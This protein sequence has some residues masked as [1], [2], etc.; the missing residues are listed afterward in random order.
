MNSK[1]TIAFATALMICGCK[2]QK[3]TISTEAPAPLVLIDEAFRKPINDKALYAATFDAVP[4]DTAYIHHDTLHINTKKVHGCETENFKLMWSGSIAKLQPRQ[5]NLKLLQ[6][7]D[8]S[9]KEKH[10]FRLTYNISDLYLK[11]DTLNDTTTLVHLNGWKEGM[12]FNHPPG[13]NAKN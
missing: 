3:K 8:A 1:H 9:C 6:T 13:K 11:K 2:T 10:I 5:A 4:I 7:V 12:I